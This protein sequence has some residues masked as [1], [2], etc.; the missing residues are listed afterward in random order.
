ML[1]S[2]K[3][4]LNII[5]YIIMF[6]FAIWLGYIIIYG[7]GGIVER[8]ET[9]KTLD[10]LEEEIRELE[11][12][13]ERVDLQIKDLKNNKKNIESFARELGYKNEGEVIF[14]FARKGKRK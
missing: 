11:F 8:R 2:G 10:L 5:I 12:Q 14:R 3:K 1:R 13:I 9:Q 4:I 7:N 6:S